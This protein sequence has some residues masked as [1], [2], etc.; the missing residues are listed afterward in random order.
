MVLG[1]EITTNNNYGIRLSIEYPL[2]GEPQFERLSC[3]LHSSCKKS[4]SPAR[5]RLPGEWPCLLPG[6]GDGKR[7]SQVN[8]EQMKMLPNW[9]CED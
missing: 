2:D 1:V 9:R 3:P 4:L 8:I 7:G 5:N 6:H